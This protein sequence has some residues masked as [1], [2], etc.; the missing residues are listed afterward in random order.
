MTKHLTIFYI[1]DLYGI[2][3]ASLFIFTHLQQYLW[4]QEKRSWAQTH[5]NWG[6]HNRIKSRINH[7]VENPEQR[8]SEKRKHIELRNRNIEKKYTP[9]KFPWREFGGRQRRSMNWICSTRSN[10]SNLMLYLVHQKIYV[11]R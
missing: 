9:I 6:W 3:S 4:N 11:G 7:I 2:L 8:D 10:R 5:F 1:P